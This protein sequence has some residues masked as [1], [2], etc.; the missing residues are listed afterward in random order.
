[1][2]KKRKQSS[3]PQVDAAAPDEKP[4][5]FSFKHL[6][7]QNPKFDPSKCTVD[8]FCKLFALMQRFS[9]WTVGQF[10]DQNN[11]E[12]RHII[13]FAK[14]SEPD[15]FQNIPKADPNQ[16]AYSEGWQFGV[17][18]EVQWSD[19]RAHGILLDDTF[20]IVWLDPGHKLYPKT[21]ALGA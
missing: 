21:L 15:G 8:Y 2:A 16:F 14:T 10:V 7:M 9:T 11:Q 5:R 6:D 17:Y 13:D 1:M 4:L 12:R 19:W 18:P 20:Y 3:I